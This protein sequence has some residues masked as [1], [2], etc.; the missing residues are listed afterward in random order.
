MPRVLLLF[1][2]TSYRAEAFLEAARRLGVDVTV[3]SNHRQALADFAPGATLTLG[4]TDV[5]RSSATIVRFAADYPLAAIVAAGDDFTPLAAAASEALELTHHPSQAVRCARNKALMRERLSEAGFSSPWFRTTRLDE[6]P[7]AVASKIEFPCVL[8]PL[9]LSASRGVIRVDTPEQFVRAWQRIRGI[10]EQDDVVRR[11]G[12]LASELL[13]EAYLP[14]REVALEGIVSAGELRTLAVLDKPDLMDGPFFEETILVT[15]SRFPEQV[16]EDIVS[17]VSRCAAHLG[18]SDGPIHAE[19]RVDAD[20]IS[21]L[22]IAPRSIGGRCSRILRFEPGGSLEELILRHSLGMPH[23]DFLREPGAAGVMM[24]P[25]PAAGVLREVVGLEAA[26]EVPG[27]EGLE[28]TIP[29]GHTVVPLPEG[30]RYLGFLFARAET[31]DHVENALR[32]AHARIE[33]R[34]EEA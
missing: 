4:F 29:L 31:P 5:A 3:G 7:A 13:I 32:A 34:I 33:V 15:P 2:R 22:E 18:L 14:G 16:Q 19:L 21:L 20:R 1:A 27:I 9:A 23:D 6:E 30:N 17:L 11:I 24:L 28:I 12:R 8:K 10:L 26:L 25:I